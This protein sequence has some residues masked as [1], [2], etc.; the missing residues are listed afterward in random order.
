[1]MSFETP[2]VWRRRNSL[3]KMQQYS[4]FPS[5]FVWSLP[6]T[7]G[8]VWTAGSTSWEKAERLFLLVFVLLEHPL[9]RRHFSARQKI[10]RVFD[11]SSIGPEKV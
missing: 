1:M 2:G 11:K 7:I 8:I 3:R 4:A 6:R 5:Q 10:E 9:L